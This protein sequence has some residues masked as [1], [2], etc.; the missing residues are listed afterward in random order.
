MVPHVCQGSPYWAENPVGSPSIS[1]N[2]VHPVSRIPQ[3]N[4]NPA[5]KRFSSNHLTQTT[6]MAIVIANVSFF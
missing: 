2:F 5:T 1:R 6:L 4:F 3:P